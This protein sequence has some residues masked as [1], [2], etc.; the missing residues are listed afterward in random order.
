MFLHNLTVTA[1]S[2]EGSNSCN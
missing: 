2:V 1:V